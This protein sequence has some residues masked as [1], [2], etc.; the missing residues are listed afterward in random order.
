MTQFLDWCPA[1]PAPV[2]RD[3]TGKICLEKQLQAIYRNLIWNY[4]N[5]FRCIKINFR[6]LSA[7]CDNQSEAVVNAVV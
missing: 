2:Y 6:Y 1:E 4:R 3:G 5:W 7:Y